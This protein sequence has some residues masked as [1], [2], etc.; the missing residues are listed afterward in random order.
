MYQLQT[1]NASFANAVCKVNSENTMH[2]AF[3]NGFHLQCAYDQQKAQQLKNG[4][5]SW[6]ALLEGAARSSKEQMESRLALVE[7]QEIE[8]DELIIN[9]YEQLGETKQ[10]MEWNVR[11]L[12]EQIEMIKAITHLN[13]ERLDYE[14]H[15]LNKHEEENAIIK[16][17]QK[18]KITA[19]QDTS[20][21]LKSKVKDAEKNVEKEKTQLV[22]NVK[23]I[24][25]QIR[26]MEEK[27]KKF[28]VQ[29]AKTRDDMTR[30]MKNE[31][32]ALL[33]K[34]TANDQLLQSIY[35]KRPFKETSEAKLSKERLLS[36]LDSTQDSV[37]SG[38]SR[39]SSK[40]SSKP[41]SKR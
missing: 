14:I 34:I 6:Q 29:S 10:K 38:A 1:N 24:K 9:D 20:N 23:L 31:A 37:L 4:E 8:M 16:S 28:G 11:C 12:E 25:K 2:S 21:K 41:R 19:L 36:R 15:V 35:L 5:R 26:D 7:E 22:D 30:M 33:D 39:L 40:R 3:A 13:S 27:Q 18:R 32:Y 17:E